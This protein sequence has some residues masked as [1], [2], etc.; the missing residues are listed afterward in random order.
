MSNGETTLSVNQICL[1]H[2]VV[3]DDAGHDDGPDFDC[4]VLRPCHS[5]RFIVRDFSASDRGSVSFQTDGEITDVQ[6]P[7]FGDAV[8]ST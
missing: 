6:V 3:R 8:F 5:E 7:Q 1:T 2:D 4:C